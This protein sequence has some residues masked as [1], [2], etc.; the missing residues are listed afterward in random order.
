MKLITKNNSSLLMGFCAIGIFFFCSCS[1]GG[2]SITP[3][4]PYISL[5]TFYKTAAGADLLKQ[6]DSIAYKKVNLSIISKME[7]DGIVREISY[8]EGGIA[9]NWDIAT[10]LYYF[11]TYIPT[12]Y[13]AKIPIETYVRLSP[14]ITDT[15]TY[16][17][18]L[19]G[20]EEERACPDKIYYNKKLVW[21]KAKQP[22]E[23]RYLP[24]IITK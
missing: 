1:I 2:G 8:N 17:F 20:T 16:T 5:N 19:A 22:L 23:G 18:N 4:S 3:P 11:E 14:K 7:V 6:G 10:K 15:L 21:E 12:K 9:I 24:I 13:K